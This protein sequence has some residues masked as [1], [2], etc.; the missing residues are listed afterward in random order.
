MGPLAWNGVPSPRKPLMRRWPKFSDG[1]RS[2][3]ESLGDCRIVGVGRGDDE[4]KAA[5]LRAGIR[6]DE[7]AGGVGQKFGGE[8]S[9]RDGAVNFIGA[10]AEVIQLEYQLEWIRA[11][12][13]NGVRCHARRIQCSLECRRFI[14]HRQLGGEVSCG[15]QVEVEKAGSGRR[16]GVGLGGETRVGSARERRESE[17]RAMEPGS[18]EA[19]RPIKIAVAALDE[20]RIRVAAVDV[21]E[22]T[23]QR[24]K[25]AI[26]V[27]LKQCAIPV[28]PEKGCAV[29]QTV[30]GLQ[31]G[32]T[33]PFAI[34]PAKMV[35][36]GKCPL[37]TDLERGSVT[38]CPAQPSCSEEIAVQGLD[39]GGGRVASVGSVKLVDGG[40]YAIGGD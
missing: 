27:H 18:A 28:P 15:P 29:K 39:E 10:A 6:V 36:R 14:S 4:G 5:A 23:V 38:T 20:R 1:H 9:V 26:G 16:E 35:D 17:H 25:H 19:R 2:V 33:G 3:A 21:A 37:R 32:G 34:R 13:G 12:G 22:E 11:G 24:A 8:H 30:L 31:E 40:Q 7:H